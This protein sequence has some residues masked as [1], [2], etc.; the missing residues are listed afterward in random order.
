MEQA[1]LRIMFPVDI[2][3]DD[4]DKSIR[5]II[6]EKIK[7]DEEDAGGE[8][9]TSF[10]DDCGKQIPMVVIDFCKR[11]GFDGVFCRICQKN[12]KPTVEGEK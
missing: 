1:K 4:L 2:E 8:G 6:L 7:Q 5:E 9:S 12:H 11:N 10:C 3:K